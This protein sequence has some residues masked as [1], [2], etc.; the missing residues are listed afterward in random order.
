[1]GKNLGGYKPWWVITLVGPPG[2]GGRPMD[3]LHFTANREGNI[4]DP[5]NIP[6]MWKRINFSG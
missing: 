3:F 1:M 5:G 6:G 2:F 4:R